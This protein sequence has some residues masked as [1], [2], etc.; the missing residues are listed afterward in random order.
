MSKRKTG[1]TLLLASCISTAA[2]ADSMLADFQYPHPVQR[3]EFKSQGQ[4]LAM[5]YMDVQ[6]RSPNGKTVVLLHGKN[7]CG[8][9]W[10]DVV[11]P[12]LEAGYRVVIPDQVGFCKSSK[13]QAY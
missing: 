2:Y 3:Y 8:A 6:A 7:F 12:L 11:G 4:T 10:E 5:A 9:T 1:L 13:P